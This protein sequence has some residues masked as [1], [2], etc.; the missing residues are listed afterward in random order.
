DIYK[1]PNEK[2]ESAKI[3]ITDVMGLINN[4]EYEKDEYKKLFFFLSCNESDDIIGLNTQ[5]S[6]KS[7]FQA[8]RQDNR[9]MKNGYIDGLLSTFGGFSIGMKAEIK[10]ISNVVSWDKIQPMMCAKTEH[11]TFLINEVSID[12]KG[13]ITLNISK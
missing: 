1:E 10:F 4:K 7:L 9:P 2:R 8:L 13:L 3:I 12:E 11:G 6:I 5:F